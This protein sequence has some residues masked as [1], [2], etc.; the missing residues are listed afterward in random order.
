MCGVV[1][2]CLPIR[3][4]EGVRGWW[5]LGIAGYGSNLRT[6]IPISSLRR[7]DVQRQTKAGAGSRRMA[8]S[9][10][11]KRFQLRTMRSVVRCA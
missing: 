10:L 2:V 7:V 4:A 3:I 5:R 11:V 1:L 9:Q 6:L 8:G